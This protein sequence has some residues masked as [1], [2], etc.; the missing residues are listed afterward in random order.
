MVKLNKSAMAQIQQYLDQGFF[1]R[2]SFQIAFNSDNG[3]LVRVQLADYPNCFYAVL[4]PNSTQ[5]GW[6]SLESPGRHFTTAEE[7][8]HPTYEHAAGYISSWVS[9]LLK[10]VVMEE[11]LTNGDLHQLREDLARNAENLADPNQ[12][13]TADEAK[14]WEA[15]FD[16]MADR[17]R[18]LEQ[19]NE[20][21][22]GHL[23]KLLNE[24]EQLKKVSTSVPKKTWVKT[25][26]N[27]ILDYMETAAKSTITALAQGVVKAMLEHKP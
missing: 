19:K 24:L 2:H 9:R 5:S 13:F 16:A 23:H 20:L 10:E 21:H 6:R 3:E 15:K 18:E 4:Q 26:G 22:Q 27:K 1:S 25:A 12:P 17:L 11:S 14:E 8:P 7:Y